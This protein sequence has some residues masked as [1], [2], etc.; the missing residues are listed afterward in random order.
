M[1]EIVGTQTLRALCQDRKSFGDEVQSKAQPDMNALGVWIES[2]NIQRI[3]DEQDLINALGMD[4]MAA[5][6]K[7]ASIAKAEADKDVAIAQAKAAREA[8]DAKVAA[9]TEIAE[10]QNELAIKR[11]NYSSSLTQRRRLRMLLI[12][13]R[14]R[15]SV[16]RLRQQKLMQILQSR[17]E[18]LNF[19]RRKHRLQNRHLMRR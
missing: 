1:R 11:Q 17:K 7:S 10:K 4:N 9:D 15:N 14:N 8:N 13:F 3:E 12:R 16:K 6:Q 19:A 18:L 5:I 2:C